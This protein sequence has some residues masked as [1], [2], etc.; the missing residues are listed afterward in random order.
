[1]GV[2]E[3]VLHG[4]DRE[5]AAIAE[6]I[7][8]ARHG[9]GL[10]VMIEGAAGTGKS[11]LMAVAAEMG[12]ADGMRVISARAGELDQGQPFGVIRQLFEPVLSVASSDQRAR[13]LGGPAAPAAHVLG[14]GGSGDGSHAA[15]FAAMQAIYQLSSELA[16]EHPVLAAVDDAHWADGSSLHALEFL[17]RRLA[18]LPMVVFAAIRPDEP[19]ARTELLDALRDG[20]DMRLLT[21][22]LGRDAV[23][24]IVRSRMP[25]ASDEI[26]DTF[27]AATGGNP[28][29]VN[30]LLRAV[31]INGNPLRPQD[32]D[33]VTVRF[34]GDRVLRRIEPVDARAPALT[35]AMA[36]LGDGARLGNAAALAGLEVVEAGEIAHR[37]RRIEVLSSEDPVT[38][39]HPLIRASID[40]AIPDSERQLARRRAADLLRQAGAPPEDRAAHL[41]LLTPNGDPE[42]AET[43]ATAARNALDRAAPE[44]AIAWLQRALDEEAPHPSSAELRAQLG[45]AKAILR[46]PTALADLEDAYRQAPDADGQVRVGLL[47]AELLAHSGQWKAARDLI[48]ALELKVDANDARAVTEIA[49]I[50]AAVTLFDP[51]LIA[52]FD[53]HRGEYERLARLD[54]WGSYALSAPGG[55]RAF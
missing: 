39:L 48:E 31:H 19:G 28:L 14:L 21:V 9:R 44:E 35:R 24:S 27:L 2:K 30:E 55:A 17:A 47:L 43:L 1:M 42:V 10:L 54:H 4:R 11:A 53:Q 46:D 51:S 22:A 29:Y 52:D 45:W 6:A 37:L 34:L 33:A 32:V 13:L 25:E 5:I 40:D 8:G 49:A 3:V 15:G 12:A 18:D 23:A 36:I 38:F 16:A 41:S 7:E 20:A 50:R 26:C